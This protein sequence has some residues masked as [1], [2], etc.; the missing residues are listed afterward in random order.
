MSYDGDKDDPGHTHPGNPSDDPGHTHPGNP[1][2]ENSEATPYRSGLDLNRFQKLVEETSPP[3]APLL[4]GRA[5]QHR[6]D[7]QYRAVAESVQDDADSN[8]SVAGTSEFS[9]IPW[10]G[11][12]GGNS[13]LDSNVS[14]VYNSY[15]TGDSQQGV[16]PD[17]HQQMLP[18][19]HGTLFEHPPVSQSQEAPSNQQRGVPSQH[20]T[21]SEHPLHVSYKMPNQQIPRPPTGGDSSLERDGGGVVRSGAASSETNKIHTDLAN[22]GKAS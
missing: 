6:H 5:P 7:S 13:T 14:S 3:S 17:H 19:Q 8:G 18:R 1:S 2:D 12:Q 15:N 4:T 22:L 10:D 11:G 21:L 9:S 16:L 20:V